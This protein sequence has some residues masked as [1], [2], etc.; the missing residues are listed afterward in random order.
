[1][2]VGQKPTHRH[3]L[4]VRNSTPNPTPTPNPNLTRVTVPHDHGNLIKTDKYRSLGIV[5]LFLL[6]F[7]PVKDESGALSILLVI[8]P[9]TFLKMWAVPNE[10]NF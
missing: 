8:H 9:S 7:Q 1:M 2:I 10:E 6:A 4:L 3:R 5:S